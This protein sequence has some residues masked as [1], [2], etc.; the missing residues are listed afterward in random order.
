MNVPGSMQDQLYQ[1][2][3]WLLFTTVNTFSTT[4]DIYSKYSTSR[5]L[6]IILG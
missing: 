5:L 4:N 3:L 6:S 1:H 2:H